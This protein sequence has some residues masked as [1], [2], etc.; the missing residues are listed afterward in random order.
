LLAGGGLGGRGLLAG[1]AEGSGGLGGLLDGAGGL[2][3]VPIQNSVQG[4]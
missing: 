1:V 2:Q 3:R 4:L